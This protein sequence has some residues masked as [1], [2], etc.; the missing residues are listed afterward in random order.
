MDLSKPADPTSAVTADGSQLGLLGSFTRKSTF[1]RPVEHARGPCPDEQRK[2]LLQQGNQLFAN[3]W[4]G[5]AH[6]Q[7]DL[8]AG[9]DLLRM[10]EDILE[11]LVDDYLKFNGFFTAHNVKFQ[12]AATDLRT[13]KK[14]MPLPAMW[15]LSGFIQGVKE[16]NACGS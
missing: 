16:L 7:R 13:S 9:W 14:M 2:S 1:V 11:Q 6:D 15:T 5:I 10:K 4:H 12:P 8:S 3:F